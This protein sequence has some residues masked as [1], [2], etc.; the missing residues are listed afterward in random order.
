MSVP[1]SELGKSLKCPKCPKEWGEISDLKV[2]DKNVEMQFKCKKCGVAFS[3]IYSINQYIR[4]A[5]AGLIEPKSWITDFQRKFLIKKGQFV[6]IPDGIDGIL[7]LKDDDLPL[8]QQVGEKLICSEKNCNR[9][10][11]FT[12]EKFKKNDVVLSAYCP[13]KG[14]TKKMELDIRAFLILGKAQIFDYDLVSQV[15]EELSIEKEGFNV[16]QMY[17]LEQSILAP[18][19]QEALGMTG[20]VQRT[21]CYICGADIAPGAERCSKCGSDL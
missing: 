9:F 20:E 10:Y 8:I 15:R 7:I 4:M 5:E 11:K 19:V 21:K 14:K 16:D 2:T 13:C 3:R 12:F 17:G 1:L 18:W 6:K